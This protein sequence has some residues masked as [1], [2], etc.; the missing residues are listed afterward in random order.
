LLDATAT[1]TTNA[2]NSLPLVKDVFPELRKKA[3]V[4]NFSLLYGKT[5]Y[6]LTKDWGVDLEEAQLMIDKWFAAFPEIRDWIRDVEKNARN[7]V[8]PLTVM[9]RMRPLKAAMH[10]RQRVWEGALRQVVNSPIQGS[11]ADIVTLAMLQLNDDPRLH[12]LGFRQ[13]LQ[14]H[15]EIVL[16]GPEESAEEALERVLAIMENPLPFDFCVPLKVDARISQSWGQ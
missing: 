13:I 10:K 12:A 6:G 9:G 11:A 3:K 2:T 8:F 1:T 14:I 4:L 15:D 5:A 16:E 7:G